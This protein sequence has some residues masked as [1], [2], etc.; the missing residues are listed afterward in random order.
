MPSIFFINELF[1]LYSPEI[2]DRLDGSCCCYLCYCLYGCLIYCDIHNLFQ[3]VATEQ[4]KK[5]TYYY[6][7]IIILTVITIIIMKWQGG[8]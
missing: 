2:K 6:I 5:V 4:K 7:L 1:I 8:L 3:N